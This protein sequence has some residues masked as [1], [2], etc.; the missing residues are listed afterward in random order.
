MERPDERRT[1]RAVDAPVEQGLVVAGGAAG[2]GAS[3]A[4]R[5]VGSAP[6]AAEAVEA[7]RAARAARISGVPHQPGPASDAA[8]AGHPGAAT[9]GAAPAEQAVR[10]RR[11]VRGTGVGGPG[12][13]PVLPRAESDQLALRLQNAVIGFVDGPWRSVEEAD[14]LF[15]EASARIAACLAER[16]RLLRTAWQEG[17]ADGDGAGTEQLRTALRDYRDVMQRLLKV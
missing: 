3:A 9:G 14:A 13:K 6:R 1:A 17:A 5:A 7:R 4:P 10:D 11:G 16:R 12:V 8:P 15:E 2:A